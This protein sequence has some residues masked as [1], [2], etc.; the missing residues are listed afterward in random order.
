MRNEGDDIFE[1]VD[2]VIRIAEEAGVRA[3]ISHH[4]AIGRRNF[5][6]VSRT[7]ETIEK[8][9]RRGLAITVDVY[10]YEF[11]QASS[12]VRICLKPRGRTSRARRL[13]VS[14]PQ[15][16]DPPPCWPTSP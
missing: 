14:T 7:L 3:E 8:A 9:R 6:K 5:G 12:L 15:T 11:S 1:A 10:P 16:R 2:E 13:P 4:K